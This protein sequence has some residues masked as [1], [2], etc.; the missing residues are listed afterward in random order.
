M[1][2][3]LSP[4]QFAREGERLCHTGDGEAVTSFRDELRRAYDADPSRF[5]SPILDRLANVCHTLEGIL[6]F[7][8]QRPESAQLMTGLASLRADFDRELV[9]RE[10][11]KEHKSEPL[12]LAGLNGPDPA[13]F[14]IS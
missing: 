9:V 8:S 1:F 11:A 4:Q 7:D 12:S 2:S 14:K 13:L 6:R 5:S 10:G 3:D